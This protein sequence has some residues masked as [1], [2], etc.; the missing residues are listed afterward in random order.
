VL[1][2]TKCDL[3]DEE[4]IKA[5][6]KE[7]PKNVPTVFISAVSGE[8]IQQLKDLIWNEMHDE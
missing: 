5:F 4:L 7:L 6:R 1:A 3:A 8:G 2:I